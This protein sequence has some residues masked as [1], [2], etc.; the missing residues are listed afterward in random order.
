[1][2]LENFSL[3]VVYER[4]GKETVVT[5]GDPVVS[6]EKVIE[7]NRLTVILRASERVRLRSARLVHMRSFSDDE[8]I[9]GGGYQSWTRTLEYGVKDAQRGLL[10]VAKI[11]AVRKFAAP[12][13]DYDF[14]I[15]GGKLIH[16]H[17]YTYIRNGAN[18]ELFG[19]LD[20]STG[21]TVFYADIREHV[22][23]VVKDVEGV[24]TEGEYKLFD[25][26]R[27]EGSY[28][29]VFDAYFKAY[30]I[31]APVR[32]IKRL[33]GYTSW[34]NYYQNIDEK[35]ILRDLDGLYKTAGNRANIFQ[36]DDGYESM[37]GDWLAVDEKKFPSGMK[38]M[39]DAIH[40]K[41]YLAG[42]W[43][44]PFAAQFKAKVVSEHPD[45]LVRDKKG[46]PVV[47]GFAWNGFYALDSENPDV[48]EYLKKVFA[49]VLGEWGYD[50]VKLDFLYAA[51]MHPRGG[52]SRGRLMHD[53][54]A[55][56][57]ECVG[58]KLL[59]GCG[60]P[61]TSSFGFADAC[62]TGC[63]AEL[64]FQDRYYVSCTNQEII[65]TRHSIENTVFRRHLNGRVFLSD[66]DVFFLRDGGMK[67]VDYTD[68]QKELLAKVN[69]MFGSVLFVSDNTG[70]YDH[71]KREMLL[72][73]YE[74]FEGKVRAVERRGRNGID[75]YFNENGTDKIMSFDL[76]TG[77]M[78][79]KAE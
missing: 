32:K 14:V 45:W 78:S 13:G 53:A 63:D 20:E 6:V 28:D 69:K 46:K 68:T 17:G 72:D 38:A 33:A 7:G 23:A 48:R 11:P 70:E 30:P 26:M 54:M 50:M 12:T 61:M 2:K 52:K 37:V 31:K 25:F 44:A 22:F 40:S 71:K 65:S 34:Y 62:R 58:G 59:L 3:R 36:I 9:F 75:I 49:T 74:P 73:A 29:E 19:S 55:F 43:L 1:M 15:Y 41:G 18:V 21:F 56:L 10:N 39:A 5:E 35:I 16:S 67:K 60:V 57:R 42:L 27:A 47:A 51:C 77:D 4:N 64:S 24:E 66:P 8:R 79:V 76:S